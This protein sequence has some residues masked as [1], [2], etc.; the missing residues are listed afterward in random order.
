M[1]LQI[2]KDKNKFSRNDRALFNYYKKMINTPEPFPLKKFRKTAWEKMEKLFWGELDREDWRYTNYDVFFPDTFITGSYQIAISGLSDKD[3]SSGVRAIKYPE[4]MNDVIPFISDNGQVNFFYDKWTLLNASLFNK[5][6]FVDIRKNYK[7]EGTLNIQ[8]D[9]AGGGLE[10]PLTYIKLNEGSELNLIE[11]YNGGTSG[12]EHVISNT[13]IDLAANSKLNYVFIQNLSKDSK[14]L[15]Y[16]NAFLDRDAELQVHSIHLGSKT[17]RVIQ[18]VELR[19]PGSYLKNFGL[20]YGS[21]RQHF[22][23]ET[24]QV[25]KAPHTGGELLYRHVLADRAKSIFKGKIVI[26]KDETFC[27]A[28]QKNENLLLSPKAEAISLPKLE[29]LNNEVQC[30]HG[31]TISSID[32]EQLFYLT[33]RGIGMDNA[34]KIIVEGFFEEIIK[35]SA[36]Q[37]IAEVISRKVKEVL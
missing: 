11:E 5:G 29:I 21:G 33:S 36:T 7:A 17:G 9:F 31:V 25:H 2:I 34:R 3:V 15:F 10:I 32:D 19:E 8:H 23:I 12:S 22:D 14:G 26:E 4:Q 6:V 30:S 20:L 1:N 28:T 13:I 37:S 35:K 27:S 16:Q 18:N 24:N